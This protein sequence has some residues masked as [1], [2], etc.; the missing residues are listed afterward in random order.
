M[1][2][3]GLQE[4]GHGGLPVQLSS[5]TGVRRG[6]EDSGG[7]AGDLKDIHKLIGPPQQHPVSGWIHHTFLVRERERERERAH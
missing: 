2:G 7:N 1:V 5:L 6:A 3:G 4:Q